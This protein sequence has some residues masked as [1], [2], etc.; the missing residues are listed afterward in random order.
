MLA[1]TGRSAKRET[2]RLEYGMDFRKPE[3]RREVFL[4]LYEYSLRYR[5]HP[6]SVYFL[7]PYL[8]TASKMSREERLWYMFLEGCCLN[9]VTA[10]TLWKRFPSL[11]KLNLSALARYFTER[12]ALLE[13]D[14]DRRY[15]KKDFVAS[16]ESYYTLMTR[17][18]LKQADWYAAQWGGNPSE[19]WKLTWKGIECDFTTFGRMTIYGFLEQLR[20]LG[21][22][23][24]C[25]SLMLRD[26]AGS[27]SHRNGL[28]KVLGRDDLDHH[29]TN[30]AF[31]GRYSSKQLDWLTEEGA[32]LLGEAKRRAPD[33]D[34]LTLESALCT[35]KSCFRRN[36]RYPNCYSDMTYDRIRR[37]EIAFEKVKRYP[38]EE[39]DVFWAARREV[40]P[41]HMRLEDNPG[42][43]GLRPEKQ[44]HFRDTGQMV[45]MNYD[46][47][48]FRNSFNDRLA[49]GETI[50]RRRF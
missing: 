27:R 10:F 44:N 46:W 5:I 28:L 43:P 11:K 15:Q 3:Y 14:V 38:N 47:P 32:E 31:D 45:M 50:G 4:R 39:F 18:G 2:S 19:N 49:A 25:D 35:F 40:L 12:R 7:Q 22:P 30:P 6:G 20:L 16:V 37:A 9:P 8:V 29:K 41:K 23:Y 17:Y 48:C 26:I 36:R 21:E 24:E 1:E 42:D 13:W 33:A 34:Y